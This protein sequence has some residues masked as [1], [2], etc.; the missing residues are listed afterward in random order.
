MNQPTSPLLLL[1]T[2]P[3]SDATQPTQDRPARPHALPLPPQ[4]SREAPGLGVIPL[5]GVPV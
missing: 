2:A 5:T 1:V 4:R 3:W